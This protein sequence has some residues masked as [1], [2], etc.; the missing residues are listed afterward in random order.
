M[1]VLTVVGVGV[2]SWRSLRWWIRHSSSLSEKNLTSVIFNCDLMRYLF[3]C[4]K[5]RLIN[6]YY[7]SVLQ[8]VA[9]PAQLY[10]FIDANENKDGW[11]GAGV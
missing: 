8:V 6:Q 1:G 11:V 7:K 2:N 4:F 9:L 5:N 10:F 3:L